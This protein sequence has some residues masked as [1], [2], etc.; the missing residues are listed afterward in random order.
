MP[1]G[2]TSRIHDLQEVSFK[3]F[4]SQCAYAFMIEGRDSH[5]D[6]LPESISDESIVYHREKLEEAKS[7]LDSF[8]RLS[9]DDL[10]DQNSLKHSADVESWSR[11]TQKNA[12]IMAAYNKMLNEVLAW[13]PPTETHQGLKDFMLEQ[14]RSSIEF[15]NYT[16]SMPVRPSTEEFKQKKIDSLKWN[17]NYHEEYLQKAIDNHA[18]R[19]EWLDQLKKSIGV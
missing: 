8:L 7:A 18:A 5:S 6:K 10:A 14:L 2:Y 9:Y 17:I 3:D 1:T 12:K 19:T 15:D 11:E 13:K 16:P 4:V